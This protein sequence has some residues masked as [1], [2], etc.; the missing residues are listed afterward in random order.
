RVAGALT[1][2]EVL[3]LH[4]R[5]PAETQEAVLRPR[6]GGPR[7]VVLATSVAESS[8][9]VPGVRSVVDAGLSREPR[10]DHARGLGA[11]TTVRSSRATA[12]RRAGGAGREARGRVSRCWSA[13]EHDRLPGH[14]RPEIELADLTA[15]ALQA[16]C[17]GDPDAAGLALLDP[18]P[19]AA[20]RAAR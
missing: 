3:Q 15:F 17:W 5:A 16:A 10:M 19:P 11:L 12:A 13:A 7:R 6:E 9:T 1:G 14:P 2:L 20:L 18:P 4:G 8:L